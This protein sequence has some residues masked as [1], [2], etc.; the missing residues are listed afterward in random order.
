MINDRRKA[1]R[2]TD[3]RIAVTLGATW[4]GV[5]AEDDPRVL[6]ISKSGCFIQ[7][8]ED[9]FAGETLAFSIEYPVGG[10]LQLRGEIV[11]E[12]PPH[13][14]GLRFTGLTDIEQSSLEFLVEYCDKQPEPELLSF[15][16]ESS[17]IES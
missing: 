4:D 13:G 10:W 14:Y 17:A 8:T 12:L 5:E 6:D 11:R 2:R 9:F 15:G 16:P 7:T 3:D 1:K